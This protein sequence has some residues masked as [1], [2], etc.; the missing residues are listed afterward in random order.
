M[1]CSSTYMPRPGPRVAMI[2]QNGNPA[3]VR[4]G[5]VYEGGIFGGDIVEA[6]RGNPE[7]EEHARAYKNGMMGGFFATLGGGASMGAGLAFLTLGTAARSTGGEGTTEQTTGGLL[8]AGGLGAYITGLV[9]MLNAQPRLWDAI[10]TYNDGIPMGPMPY[11][12]PP[13]GYVYPPAPPSTLPLPSPAPPNATPPS[14]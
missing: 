3:Y 2:Q 13:P 8:L 12:Y 14:R 10:N 5:R 6:V 11:G 7:A 4:D 1:G 9:L